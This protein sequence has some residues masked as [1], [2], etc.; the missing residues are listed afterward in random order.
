MNDQ[1]DSSL[2]RERALML[3][4]IAFALVASILA[5]IGLYG[6]MSFHVARRTSEIGIRLALGEARRSVFAGI[7]RYATRLAVVGIVVGV[8]CAVVATRLVSAFL[9]GLSPR[10]PLTLTGVSI[11]LLGTAL[12]AGWLPARRAA[13][14]DPLAAIRTE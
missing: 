10:D 7:L 5:C 2:V 6:V 13:R 14:V 1:V 8:I 12:L 3:L 11:G 9:Y 4:S